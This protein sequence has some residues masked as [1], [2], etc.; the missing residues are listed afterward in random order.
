MMRAVQ[1]GLTL[2][3]LMIIVAIIGII[4]SVAIPAI[5]DYMVGEKTTSAVSRPR[6]AFSVRNGGLRNAPS[7][8]PPRFLHEPDA[9]G[10][11]RTC[12]SIAR[13]TFG[14]AAATAPDRR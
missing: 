4:A 10:P 3:E 11:R 8:P 2:I 7:R 6:R 9:F 5:E 1:K 14:F 13:S 12:G